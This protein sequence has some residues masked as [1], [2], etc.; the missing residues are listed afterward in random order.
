[1]NRVVGFCASVTNS[2]WNKKN[3]SISTNIYKYD[4]QSGWETWRSIDGAISNGLIIAVLEFTV[5]INFI[6][7][8]EQMLEL[9]ECTWNQQWFLKQGGRKSKT[10]IYKEETMWKKKRKKSYN[11]LWLKKLFPANSSHSFQ[12]AAEGFHEGPACLNKFHSER[13]SCK[14]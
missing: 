1:M 5:W 11:T 10:K 13:I 12:E 2:V 14:S 4:Q 6:I 3:V 7:S 9:D 8:N